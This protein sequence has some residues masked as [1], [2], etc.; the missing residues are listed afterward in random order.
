MSIVLAKNIRQLR[1]A[2]S[3]DEWSGELREIGIRCSKTTAHRWERALQ[4]PDPKTLKILA[5]KFDID[6]EDLFR[7]DL[8]RNGQIVREP[9]KM[10]ISPDLENL[11]NIIETNQG[12][13][14]FVEMCSKLEEDQLNVMTM[15][16]QA[17]QAAR[18]TIIE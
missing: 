18:K 5:G 9:Q 7:R 17:L 15:T 6:L 3:L 4:W 11:H 10:T 1:G 8:L 2:R 16:V 12:F 14:N 13:Q